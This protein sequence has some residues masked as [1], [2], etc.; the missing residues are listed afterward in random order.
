MPVTIYER[1]M[2]LLMTLFIN[3]PVQPK[4]IWLYYLFITDPP[5]HKQEN[6]CR[7]TKKLYITRTFCELRNGAGFWYFWSI[8][9]LTEKTVFSLS[10]KDNKKTLHLPSCSHKCLKS[11]RK[12]ICQYHCSSEWELLST[13]TWNLWPVHHKNRSIQ[14]FSPTGTPKLIIFGKWHHFSFLCYTHLPSR[15]THYIASIKGEDG[16]GRIKHASIPR[17]DG[18]PTIEQHLTLKAGQG[19][20]A[21]LR[22]C[23]LLKIMCFKWEKQNPRK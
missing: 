20:R 21:C 16:C 15:V 5:Q 1:W 4:F 18:H 9:Q 19:E 8:C 12:C 10:I 11:A 23:Q 7:L 2:W 13:W 14:H 3:S 22:R 6:L 17:E